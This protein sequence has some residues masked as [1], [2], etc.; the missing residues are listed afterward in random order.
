ML[1]FYPLSS[2]P[3]SSLGL[4]PIEF[5]STVS[6]NSSA[7]SGLSTSITLYSTI[8]ANSSAISG[9]S[10]SITLAS[11]VSVNTSVSVNLTETILF[12]STISANSS[13]TAEL[14]S[15]ITLASTVSV[16]SS[17]TAGLSTSIILASTVSGN[18]SVSANLYVAK[19]NLS[20]VILVL[21]PDNKYVIT[22]VPVS[23]TVQCYPENNIVLK[24]SNNIEVLYFD[25]NVVIT[26]D[27]NEYLTMSN[28][29]KS[30]IG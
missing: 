7:V 12:Y 28:S 9:L 1:G 5:N 20:N 19:L 24:E 27:P 14:S 15:S 29:N 23:M 3:I 6:A 2:N 25:K 10:T 22:S 21:S 16:L 11:T 26:S 13:S 4:S 30:I 17:A 8:S 18:T